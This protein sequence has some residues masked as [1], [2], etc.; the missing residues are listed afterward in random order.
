MRQTLLGSKRGD[1][2]CHHEKQERID[3]GIGV[4]INRKK[5]RIYGKEMKRWRGK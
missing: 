1:P 3:I 5:V 2:W 4:V